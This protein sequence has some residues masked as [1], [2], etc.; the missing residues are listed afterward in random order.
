MK[1]LEILL[2]VGDRTH[3]RSTIKI[4]RCSKS[5]ISVRVDPPGGQ[6][7]EENSFPIRNFEEAYNATWEIRG[8]VGCNVVRSKEF[9]ELLEMI[10][11]V[12]QIPNP[13]TKRD[14]TCT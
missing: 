3:G 14:C 8:M 5:V 7:C 1:V 2:E 11:Q 9:Q 13:K 4:C 12:I 10:Q 6:K